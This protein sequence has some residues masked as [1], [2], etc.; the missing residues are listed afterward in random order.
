MPQPFT[1]WKVLPHGKLSK[2]DDNILS[3]I[4]T[5]PMPVGNMTRRMTVVRLRGGRLVIFSAIALDESEMRVLEDFGKPAFLIVPNDHHRLDAKPWKDR[6]PSI[7]VIAPPGARKKIAQAVAVDTTKPDFGDSDV[8][9]I[10]VPGTQAREFALE[11]IGPTGTTLVL[12]DI[13]ANIRDSSGLGGW[14]LRL[15]GFAGDRPNVPVPIKWV[16]IKDKAAFAAQLRRWAELATLKRVL[17]SHGSAIIDEP[18]RI[19]RELAVSLE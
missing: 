8:A 15:M 3:V 18:S 19:L 7:Q 4:G 9:L 11:V 17:V 6:Y 14:L 1:Q 2:I 16:L 12:N 5:I 10:T 13:I